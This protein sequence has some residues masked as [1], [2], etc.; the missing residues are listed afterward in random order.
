M[1]SV[2]HTRALSHRYRST[3]VLR[4]LDLDVPF[5]SLL[6][7][8]GPNGAGK[9]TLL[10]IL[11]GLL[12]PSGGEVTVLGRPPAMLR[13]DERSRMSYLAEGQRL[14]DWMT[15]AQLMRYLKPLRPRWNAELAE[16]LLRR[17]RV[18]RDRPIRSLSRGE[19]MKA[20]L[21]CALAP[22]PELLIMDE[23][24]TGMDALVKDEIVEGL[25]EV[26]GEGR[27][28][29]LVS[30]HDIGELEALADRVAILDEGRLIVDEA[31]DV[32]KGRF[33]RVEVTL[34]TGSLVPLSEL[35]PDWIG[36]Q[37][38][39]LRTSFLIADHGALGWQTEVRSR[40]P[41]ARRVDIRGATLREIFVGLL[42]DGL[43]GQG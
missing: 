7:L 37:R 6:A 16:D 23:P 20:A 32:L 11:V 38:A 3:P 19:T 17:L 36:I 39:G 27:W 24:F 2:I 13:P 18:P 43:A 26:L 34:E 40:F 15:V 41:G 42:R 9:T 29:V 1:D 14:P 4:D 31:M 12:R 33:K 22:M 21:L 5:G 28:S 25:L 10:K 30:S 8:L 35:P